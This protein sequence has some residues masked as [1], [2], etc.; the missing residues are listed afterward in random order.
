[1]MLQSVVLLTL[2]PMPCDPE[3]I[4]ANKGELSH[5]TCSYTGINVAAYHGD[6]TDANRARLQD[7]WTHGHIAVLVATVAFG[8]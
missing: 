8:L 2:L 7:D 3:A 6:M 5:Y 1:V 4:T